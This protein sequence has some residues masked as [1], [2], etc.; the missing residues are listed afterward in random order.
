LLFR[1]KGNAYL[2]STGSELAINYN[3]KSVLENHHVSFTFKVLN[4]KE[5]NIFENFT[6]TEYKQIRK[7][8]I[9]IVL[10]TDLATHFYEL[11]NFKGRV[12]TLSIKFK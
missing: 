3:D 8:M 6:P 10:C 11:G 12:V 1:G 4:D 7:L 9:N 2:I 5:Y